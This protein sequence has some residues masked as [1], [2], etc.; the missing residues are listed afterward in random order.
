MTVQSPPRLMLV[1]DNLDTASLIIE[2]LQDYYGEP[3]L[4]HCIGVDEALEIDPS[5]V[6]LVLSDMN[7]PD[8][9]GLQLM[10]GML[11][12]RPDLPI[13][14]V[15]AE[16]NLG[17]AMQAIKRGAYDYIV[18]AGDYLFSIPI[19]VEKNLAMWRT[20]QENRRL[21]EQLTRTLD[22]VRIKN[23]QLEEMVAKLEMAAAT[24]PLTGLANRRSIAQ[25]LERYFAEAHR[26]EHELACIMIDL[27]GFKQINDTLG[28]QK[29]DEL[30]VC[31]ARVL[32]ANCR[33]CD[34][35]GRFG[36]DEFILIL[37]ETELETA[38]NAAKRI[39]DEFVTVA[40][41][42]FAG[43]SQEGCV[44]MSIG[45]ACMRDCQPT[46]CEQLIANADLALY[47]AKGGQE[48]PSTL[49]LVLADRPA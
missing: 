13:V 10:D 11:E 39:S 22:E 41:A 1:E 5:E 16:G 42:I 47:Q 17:N 49:R 24:D 12:R 2:T 27:D 35:A 18:K 36:G 14:V 32:E 23:H 29:G 38:K 34:V 33:R 19:V 43:T 6:D 28:H 48:T 44:T 46:T 9:S 31:T 40:R 21:Q 37:P 15:T 25:S 4:E 20:K 45:V 7:L 30:L 3:C 26:Y 8:G